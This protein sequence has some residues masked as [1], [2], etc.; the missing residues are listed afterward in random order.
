MPLE[1]GVAPAAVIADLRFVSADRSAVICGPNWDCPVTANSFRLAWI[2]SSALCR[3]DVLD[4]ELSVVRFCTEAFNL[5]AEAQNAAGLPLGCGLAGVLAIAV[6]DGAG[7][8][9]VFPL[10]PHPAI[11]A[12]TQSRTAG[13]AAR[14]GG[15]RSRRVVRVITADMASS[16]RRDGA[17]CR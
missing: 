11:A 2:L 14:I 1:F 7:E 3:S 13:T 6:G 15:R 9:A 8:D 10:L 12:H 5:S 4:E 16:Y 17:G